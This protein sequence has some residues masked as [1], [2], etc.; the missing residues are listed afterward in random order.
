ME[1][2]LFW[3]GYRYIEWVQ[4]A[5]SLL[6]IEKSHIEFIKIEKSSLKGA[7]HLL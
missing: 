4:K 1:G 5:L 2:T 6:N 3:E 7:A